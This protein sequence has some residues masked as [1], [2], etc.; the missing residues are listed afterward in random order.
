MLDL[1]SIEYLQTVEGLE[2]LYGM[3]PLL[4]LEKLWISRRNIGSGIMG[5]CVLT[6]VG[7]AGT[8][9]SPRG[10]DGPTVIA[11]DEHTLA[12]IGAV[13]SLDVIL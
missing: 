3:R 4:R 8:D 13:K 6:T 11:L 9:G 1:N 7:S 2:A 10:D 12:P 5:F